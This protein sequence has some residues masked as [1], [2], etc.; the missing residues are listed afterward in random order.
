MNRDIVKRYISLR[1][2]AW[3]VSFLVERRV[4]TVSILLSV[5]VA[6][7]FILSAGMGDLFLT[8]LEVLHVLTGSGEES[9]SVIVT[10]FRLPRIFVAM[11][12][13]AALAVSG[14]ILQGIIR[15]PYVSPDIVGIT[16]GASV[17]AVSF[18][19]FFSGVLSIHLQPLFAFVGAGL[20]AF[21]IYS[22]A[23]RRGV[24]PIRL[25]LI[26]IGFSEGLRA[27]TML[28]IVLSPMYAASQAYI[29]LTGTVY[30]ATWDQVF[31][32]LPWVVVF[33]TAAFLYVGNV[34]VQ[35]LG[36]DIAASL[37]S[38]VQR[39]RVVLLLISVVLAGA[40]VAIAGAV[41][42]VGLIAPHIAR[43]LVGPSFGGMLPVSALTGALIVMLADLVARTAF[44]PLDIPVGVFT[45]AVGAPFFIYL[46]YRTR[47]Q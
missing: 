20:I 23:W 14:A 17:A 16:G 9:Q 35:Q 18:I 12:V 30:A 46:L 1:C 43:K 27:V 42:F 8:P 44:S 47:K 37:G 5:S 15:N 41:G 45:A 39:D 4:A 36:D 11:L 6:A 3:P 26:G 21:V 29:W 32:L 31:T 38:S 33:I 22:L 13:G 19:Y 10:T 25:V 2:A 28:M 24:T 40:A 7:V 34:N